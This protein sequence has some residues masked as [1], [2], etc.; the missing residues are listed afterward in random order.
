MP[1][2]GGIVAEDSMFTTF[3]MVT[4][5]LLRRTGPGTGDV[6]SISSSKVYLTSHYDA[7]PHLCTH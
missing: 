7:P 4:I 6:E 5:Y 2:T 1:T 3:W